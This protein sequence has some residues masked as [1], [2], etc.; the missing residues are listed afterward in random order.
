M[1][2]PKDLINMFEKL[3]VIRIIGLKIAEGYWKPDAFKAE[4]L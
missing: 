2:Q 4:V 1:A 3:W